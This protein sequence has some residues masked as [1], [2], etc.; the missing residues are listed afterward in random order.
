MDYS[1]DGNLIWVCFQKDTG[2]CWSYP[3]P[4]VRLHANE[5]MRRGTTTHSGD[6]SGFNMYSQSPPPD[7]KDYRWNAVNQRWEPVGH[8]VTAEDI[9]YHHS[10][11]LSAMCG[12]EAED[13]SP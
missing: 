3:N 13:M 5:T 9:R 2:E 8:V 11:H 7:G 10:E 1:T 6:K 12:G 4:V